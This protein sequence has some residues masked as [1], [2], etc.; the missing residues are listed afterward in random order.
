MRSSDLNQIGGLHRDC[1][2]ESVSIFSAL[3]DDVI[4]HFYKQALEESGC[5]VTVL[6]E[7]GSGHI[8]GLAFGTTRPGFQGRFLRNHFLLFCWSVFKGLF[9]NKAVWKLLWL[10]LRK[11]TGPPLTEYGPDLADV[12]VPAP[13]GQEAMFLLVGVSSQC[14]GGG[15]AER[16]VNY[17]AAQMFETGVGRIHGAIHSDNLASLILFKRLGWNIKKTSAQKV[18]IWLDRPD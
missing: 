14:R 15:N 3:S 13:K 10:R 5:T 9:V 8:I 11:K 17:F 12:G 1:F 6:E 16:L 4:K 2:S 18:T 7:P